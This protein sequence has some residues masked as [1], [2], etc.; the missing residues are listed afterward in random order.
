MET[1]VTHSPHDKHYSYSIY[2]D[3]ATASHFDDSHF[4]GPIGKLI[5]EMQ[6]RVL[7]DFLGSVNETLVLDV[8]TGTGRAALAMAAHGAQ[9]TGVDA[10]QEML[11]VAERRAAEAGLTVRYISGDAHSLDFAD[12]AFDTVVSLRMLMH[13]ADW[14]RCLG[15]L[16]RVAR[17]RVIFDY[18]PLVSAAVF[19]VGTR[20]LVQLSGRRVE[21]YRV[22]SSHAVR[23][24]LNTYGFE[25]TRMHRQFVLPIGFHK[26]IG[27][28][29]FT[30]N[31]ENLL[32]AAGLLGLI[33][34]P[35][36]ILSER[37]TS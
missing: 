21:A 32:E 10:S 11:K 33:G 6:E 1:R 31:V 17:R 27:S 22:I 34:S 29:R 35:I 4:G 14:R 9:V 5:V 3:P 19:Q 28:P 16:C 2:A 20:R 7:F 37:H 25:V 26:L 12:Q 36:T 30:L 23:S 15:E 13:T 24:V 8:G 18:P